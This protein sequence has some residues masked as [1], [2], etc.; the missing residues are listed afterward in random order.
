[1]KGRQQ[2]PVSVQR[3]GSTLLSGF[4]SAAQAKAKQIL[5]PKGSPMIP[6]AGRGQSKQIPAAQT[7]PPSTE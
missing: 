1:M 6:S 7:Q 2:S 4:S 3:Q 5:P